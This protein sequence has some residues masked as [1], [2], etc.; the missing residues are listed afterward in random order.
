MIKKVIVRSRRPGES[1]AMWCRK[2]LC[3]AAR[4]LWLYPYFEGEDVLRLESGAWAFQEKA[5]DYAIYHVD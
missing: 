3:D 1:R 5:G 2:V 4:N